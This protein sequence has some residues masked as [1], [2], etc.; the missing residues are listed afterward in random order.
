VKLSHVDDR[1]SADA[2][3]AHFL[4]DLSSA[5]PVTDLSAGE[6]LRSRAQAIFH[7]KID[8]TNHGEL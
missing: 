3:E 8:F 4:Q 1:A 6:V 5:A 2:D 7:P